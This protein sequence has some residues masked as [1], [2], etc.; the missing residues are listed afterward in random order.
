MN[1]LCQ[2]IFV[3]NTGRLYARSG[4]IHLPHLPAARKVTE[5]TELAKAILCAPA[6]SPERHHTESMPDSHQ[7]RMSIW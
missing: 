1:S 4:I 7:I 3:Q 2:F 5:I 6:N